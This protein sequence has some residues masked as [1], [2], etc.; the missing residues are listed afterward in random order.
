MATD[1]HFAATPDKSSAVGRI[2][3]LS[4]YVRILH[5]LF[6]CFCCLI[7]AD[8]ETKDHAAGPDTHSVVSHLYFGL[9]S[10]FLL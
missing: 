3:L 2:C 10:A 9:S 4:R 7:P 1:D 5:L 6:F 8:T